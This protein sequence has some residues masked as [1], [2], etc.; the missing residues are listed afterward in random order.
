MT[1]STAELLL[2]LTLRGADGLDLADLDDL[3]RVLAR[4]SVPELSEQTAV[5]CWTATQRVLARR[6]LRPDHARDLETFAARLAEH[7]RRCNTPTRSDRS[8]AAIE[9][10]LRTR[11][12]E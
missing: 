5:S 4:L 6:Q 2:T 11:R 7:A 12:D 3:L 9:R 8:T 10:Q 1:T